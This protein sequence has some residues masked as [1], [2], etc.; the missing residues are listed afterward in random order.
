[1]RI[2]RA[3]SLTLAAVAA[4]A[5]VQNACGGESVTIPPLNLVDAS[6]ADG[7]SPTDAGGVIITDANAGDANVGHSDAGGSDAGSTDAGHKADSGVDAGPRI[8]NVF[9]TSGKAD[10]SFALGNV[11]GPWAAADAICA[12]EATGSSRKGTYRAWLSYTN[13]IGTQFNA[14]SR[15]GD[16]PFS[17]FAGDDGSAPVLIAESKVKLLANGPLVPIGRTASGAPVDQDENANVAW[18]WT[19][20]NPNGQSN[21]VAGMGDDCAMWTSADNAKTGG[22]G[23]ARQIPMFTAGDWTSLGLRQCDLKRRFYCFEVP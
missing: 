19:S 8:F 9:V 6:T 10:G 17:L 4:C 5:L 22:T 15:I 1:M 3:F 11:G 16:G 14:A 13:G 21:S 20:T 12:A 2:A 18:V 23:N 7:S